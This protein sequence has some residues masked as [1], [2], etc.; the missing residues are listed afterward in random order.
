[1][2]KDLM[3][4]IL[5]GGDSDRFWP[6]GDKQSLSFLG[7]SFAYHHLSQLRKFGLTEITVVAN[8]QNEALFERL[9]HEFSDLNINL[10]LQ[11][12][13]RGMAGAIVS[14]KEFIQGKK[15]LIRNGSDIYE[16]LLISLLTAAIKKNPDGIIAGIKQK[17]YFPGG[18]LSISGDK[19]VSIVEKPHPDE[20]P[21]DIVTIGFDYFKSSDS[22]LSAISQVKSNR[23][24]VF[25]KALDMLLKD[26]LAFQ[27]LQYKGFWGYLKFPWH[28][29]NVMAY[30]LGK[31]K[32]QKGKNVSVHKSCVISGNV[33]MEDGVKIL[34]NS[35]ILGPAYIGR[36]TIIGQNCLVRES[37]IGD[38]CVVGFSSEI[39]RSYAGDN[40]WFHTNYVGDSV[41]S[42]N[43]SIG[44]GTVLA[45]LKL[46]ED[47][48]KSLVNSNKVDTGKV[49]LGSMIGS[50]VRI[51]VNASVMPGIKIG[52]NSAVGPSVVLD[53][54]LP[55][56]KLCLL[57]KVNYIVKPNTAEKPAESR[58]STLTHLK[59]S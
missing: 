5:A 18:Y 10:L 3:V 39:A 36:G 27:F 44:A 42:T 58:K 25:E 48:V 40:S 24:D 8:K 47:A 55:D 53:K 56:G 43:V 59:L 17:T 1:M 16:D 54:D 7:K 52:K 15:L 21:S 31:I 51:G 23:D 32:R 26:K 38:N 12:D 50:N 34:E 57:S 13:P 14:A 22:L 35:K 2:M 20:K 11:T 30:Y 6:L 9:K 19:V 33:F 49:K 37:M 41:V 28:A 29:L 45:N 46:R 4:L